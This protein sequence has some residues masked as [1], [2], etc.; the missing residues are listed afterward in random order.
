MEEILNAALDYAARGWPVF[1]CKP[2]GKD[3]LTAH[4]FK[5]A[6]TDPKQIKDWWTKW[7]EANVAIR[8][9][10]ISKLYVIDLDIKPDAGKYGDEELDA[11]CEEQGGLW[12]ESLTV[13]TGGGGKHLYF[14]S[15]TSYG[16]K[17][18]V[19]PAVDI[20]GEGGYV[21]AP[22]SV[23]ENGREYI[24]DIPDDNDVIVSLEEDSD[25]KMFFDEAF[26]DKKQGT[27][28]EIPESIPQGSRN[29]T[30]FKLASS[31]QEKGLS[32]SAIL[33][34]VHSE[35]EARC[36]PPLSDREIEKI[37]ESALKYPKG[38]RLIETKPEPKKPETFQGL[39]KATD[40]MEEDIPQPIVFV[41]VG[42][43]IPFLV[44]GVCILSAKPK[45]GKSWLAL[46]LCDAISKGD[47]I[48]GYK[49]KKCS[50]LYLDLETHKSIKQ[51]RLFTLQK[52]TGKI[53]NNFYIQDTACKLGS[54]FE[55]EMENFF[56][57]D[58]DIG[59][60]VVDVFQAILPPKKQNVSDYDFFYEQI[61]KIKEIADAK[62]CSIILVCHDRKT[63]DSDDP[64]SNI[65]GSTALQG[66]SDQ[67]IVMY[68]RKFNDP[69]TQLAVKGRTMDGIIE[70]AA[71]LD[72]GRWTK[73]DNKAEVRKMDE[74]KRSPILAG[75]KA[76][77]A[78]RGRWE[79]RCGAFVRECQD[80]KID[81]ELPRDKGE[82]ANLK[83]LGGLF[84]EEAF[85]D[86]LLDEGIRTKISSNGS[87]GKTYA[88]TVATVGT[89]DTVGEP[90][91]GWEK[92]DELPLDF[93]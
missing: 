4:G 62:H 52:A 28:F 23:H 72:K 33:A 48:L 32:D 47:P 55:E 73:A 65:L 69:I 89:V 71:Q 67:M 1:P 42:D 63:V 34:A 16:C 50:T 81:L 8:T 68:K 26:K 11:W 91:E 12:I 85:Q 30:I 49:T 93:G 92:I 87:G 57:E 44:E 60:I 21:I 7:P 59:L 5:D 70:I 56:N 15:S 80:L 75:V 46:Q 40:L 29:D 35:N 83:M 36:H 2:R 20:R 76:L 58:P 6:S 25:A 74:Y 90:L 14:T 53:S 27:A 18:G 45:L 77:V 88:F 82:Q 24:W 64:F 19:L 22:P 3:P 86:V 13:E 37:V 79:G 84:H 31:L 17:T 51:K 43:E 39:R 10:E 9:G 78:K 61:T 38:Q 54:G 41:G 66:A